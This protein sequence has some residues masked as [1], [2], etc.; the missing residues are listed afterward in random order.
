MA[1]EISCMQKACKLSYKSPHIYQAVMGLIL[2][3][4]FH[5]EDPYG[6]GYKVNTLLFPNIYLSASSEA[7]L[8][9]RR[10]D[11]DLKSS[12]LAMYFDT[13]SL[14]QHHTS[15]PIMVW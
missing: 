5:T 14:L 15:V 12:T 7:A 11:M 3:L 8:V 4:Y 6:V 13:A 1:I 9:A 10:W 2:N